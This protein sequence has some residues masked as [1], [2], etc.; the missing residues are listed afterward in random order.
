MRTTLTR[1]EAG[2]YRR[3]GYL[4]V[5]DLLDP[6]EL[7]IWRQAVDEAVAEM[8]DR[9]PSSRVVRH[10]QANDSYY[11]GVFVQCVNLWKTHESVRALVLD[12][13]LGKLATEVSGST[14][15]R[16]YHDHALTKE[17]WSNPTNFHVDNPMDLFHSSQATML[18]IA[19]DDATLQNGC[20]YFLPGSQKTCRFDESGTLGEEGIGRLIDSYPEWSEIEPQPV[21]VEAG[22]GIFISGLVAH[23]AGP[24]MTLQPRRAF[25]LLFMPED[26]TFNGKQSALPDEVVARTKVGDVLAD[27]EH[28]PV[29]YTRTS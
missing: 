8:V 25:A 2:S 29:L 26:A 28:L 10:N 13:R 23:A 3:D 17:P 14:G 1:E 24:N 11:S 6:D 27:D 12:E 22:S 5:P 4:V 9:D 15:V 16:L 7:R 19:L 21:E 20:L 18:W